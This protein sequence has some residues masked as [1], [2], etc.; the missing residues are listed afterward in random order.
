[1]DLYDV[2]RNGEFQLSCH[3][4]D[5]TNAIDIA[6]DRLGFNAADAIDNDWSAEPARGRR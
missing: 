3:A 5:E 1:M 4:D 2:Y 6:M